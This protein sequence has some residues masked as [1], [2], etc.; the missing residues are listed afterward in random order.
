[1]GDLVLLAVTRWHHVVD[2]VPLAV[3]RWHY[4]VDVVLLSQGGTA[5]LM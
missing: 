2:V 1:M 5:W 4:V 3:P